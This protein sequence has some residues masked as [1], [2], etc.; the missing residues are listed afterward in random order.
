M[1]QLDILLCWPEVASS[2]STDELPS[3]S[4]LAERR[5]KLWESQVKACLTKGGVTT[6][7]VN[8]LVEE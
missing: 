6:F 4:Y 2:S 5:D 7:D 1:D 8:S 3:T